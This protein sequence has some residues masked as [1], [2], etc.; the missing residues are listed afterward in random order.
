MTTVWL[1]LKNGKRKAIIL[2]HD[3]V[4]TKKCL[5]I[6]KAFGHVF[7]SCKRYSYRPVKEKTNG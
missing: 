5:R 4:C 7:A 1:H 6:E 3:H 2:K